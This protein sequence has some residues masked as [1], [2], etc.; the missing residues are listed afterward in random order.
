MRIES[1]RRDS[2]LSVPREAVQ[3]SGGKSLVYVQRD[4]LG[5][6]S[7]EVRTGDVLGDRV[8]IVEGLAAGERVVASARMI[9]GTQPR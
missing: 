6:E 1:G 8:E 7:R 5:L 9:E 3:Q 2:V 4:D